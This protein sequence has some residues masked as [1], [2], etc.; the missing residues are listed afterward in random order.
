MLPSQNRKVLNS[1]THSPPRFWLRN[2]GCILDRQVFLQ[3]ERYL[4][5]PYHFYKTGK[6]KRIKRDVMRKE[7]DEQKK[8]KIDYKEKEEGEIQGWKKRRESKENE[9]QYF[10]NSKSI[11]ITNCEINL[12]GHY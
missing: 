5:K 2:C 10:P 4:F 3:G 7:M 12:L 11:S 9:C 6:R 1:E 8:T